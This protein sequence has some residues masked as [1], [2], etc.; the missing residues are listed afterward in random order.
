MISV[1]R[2][3]YTPFQ[4]QV[5]KHDIWEQKIKRN[6]RLWW[7]RNKRTESTHFLDN[8][9]KFAIFIRNKSKS[10]SVRFLILFSSFWIL[11]S[12]LKTVFYSF[13]Y[14][15]MFQL[16]GKKEDIMNSSHTL[17]FWVFKILMWLFKV[18][19]KLCHSITFKS[20]V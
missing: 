5:I 12:P 14:W 16:V 19:K 9:W 13:T 20:L 15:I 10:S 11:F 2:H 6:H 7:G 3:N 18:K 17:C 4:P 8:C 1:K